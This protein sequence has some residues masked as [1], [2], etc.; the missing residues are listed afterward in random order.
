MKPHPTL[1]LVAG[2]CA[3][4]MAWTVQMLVSEP[5]VAQ[6]CFPATVP[7][8]TPLWSGFTPALA[9]LSL[10]CLGAAAGGAWVAWSAWRERRDPAGHAAAVDRGTAPASFLAL[11]GMMGSALFIG[12]IVFTSLAVLLVAP[13][14]KA[15]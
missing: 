11:L 6:T 5:L 9:I 14:G 13:C 15:G 8:T 2:I 10:V 4:P 7:R 3:A 12:A 1:R